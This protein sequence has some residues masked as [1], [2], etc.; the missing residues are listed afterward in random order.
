M[1]TDTIEHFLL[2]TEVERKLR[3]DLLKFTKDTDPL[4]EV[5]W[6][7]EYNGMAITGRAPKNLTENP[8]KSKVISP[9]F[10]L[11][12]LPE[13][14][15]ATDSKTTQ[16]TIFDAFEYLELIHSGDFVQAHSEFEIAPTSIE[17]IQS[18]L[19]TYRSAYEK[20]CDCKKYLDQLL[21][22]I[23][24][25][26]S[27]SEWNLVIHEATHG[28]KLSG[29]KVSTLGFKK[30][31]INHIRYPNITPRVDFASGVNFREKPMLCIF[32]EDPSHNIAG[33]N[34]YNDNDIPI[35]M[36]GFFLP[37][38]S[39]SAAFIE[40]ARPGVELPAGEDEEE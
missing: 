31:L 19:D 25:S 18:F 32:L 27:L 10:M 2:I 35:V 1:N 28:R 5:Q 16:E 11:D 21:V 12:Q 14:Y 37:P 33:H 38:K 29:H 8:S 22:E 24:E 3:A 20:S 36:I 9:E 34:V 4:E 17:F 40:M 39:I 30:E 26:E 13:N 23:S 7:R 6:I 15:S